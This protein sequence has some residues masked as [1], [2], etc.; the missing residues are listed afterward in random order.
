[1]QLT[2]EICSTVRNFVYEKLL[3]I[4]KRASA[5]VCRNSRHRIEVRDLFADHDP[6]GMLAIPECTKEE[7]A[8]VPEEQ[9]VQ[10]KAEPGSG[11]DPRLPIVV[12]FEGGELKGMAAT[13]DSIASVKKLIERSFMQEIQQVVPTDIMTLKILGQRK[14]FG[15]R[16]TIESIRSRAANLQFRLTFTGERPGAQRV[17][18]LRRSTRGMP[19]AQQRA[20][21][22]PTRLRMKAKTLTSTTTK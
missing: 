12:A 15:D 16:E 4:L 2:S 8:E 13:G 17:R 22:H 5:R 14:A 21:R 1:M 10:A 3:T 18:W 9:A 6:A 7:R 20:A 19:S 11:E